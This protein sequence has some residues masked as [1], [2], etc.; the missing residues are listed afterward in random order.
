MQIQDTADLNEEDEEEF[1]LQS[2][3]NLHRYDNDCQEE[4]KFAF[5]QEDYDQGLIANKDLVGKQ[6]T[7]NNGFPLALRLARF[8]PKEG[9]FIYTVRKAT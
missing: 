5:R 2:E 4:T 8:V 6:Y 7:M 9:H 3:F 1:D